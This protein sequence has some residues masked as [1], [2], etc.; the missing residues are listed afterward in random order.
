MGIIQSLI[1]NSKINQPMEQLMYEK[2]LGNDLYV[3]FKGLYL[4]KILL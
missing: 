3:T 4:G 2:L 1:D